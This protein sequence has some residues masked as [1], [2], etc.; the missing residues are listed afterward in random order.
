MAATIVSPDAGIHNKDTERQRPFLMRGSA[1]GSR[2]IPLYRLLWYN[3]IMIK[4]RIAFAV[5][6]HG[7]RC[8]YPGEGGD[9]D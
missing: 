9:M 4:A 3:G 5:V 2:M 1:V 6:P 7:A 8:H